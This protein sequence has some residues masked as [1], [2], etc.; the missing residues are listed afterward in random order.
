MLFKKQKPYREVGTIT[1]KLGMRRIYFGDRRYEWLNSNERFL[2][3]PNSGLNQHICIIGTSGSGKSNACK[4]IAKSI[5]GQGI[6]LAILDP[7]GEYTAF[8]ESIGASIYDASKSS[9][10]VFELDGMSE[11]EKASELLAMLKR[12]FRIGDVQGYTLHNCLMY[13]YRI[14]RQKNQTPNI[15]SLLFTIKVFYNKADLKEKR[16]LQS[17]EK[18]LSILDTERSPNSCSIEKILSENSVIVLQN[19]HN[20]E[21]QSI[22]IEGFL[23]KIYANMLSMKKGDGPRFYAIIDEAAKIRES[24][25]LAKIAAEGRKYGFG[26]IALSQR[27]KEMDKGLRAN[28]A[29]FLSFYQREPE[30]L[31]YIANYIAGGTEGSRFIEV[32]KALRTLQR[33]NAVILDSSRKDPI[34]VRFDG[35][36]SRKESAIDKIISISRGAISENEIM[37]MLKGAGYGAKEAEGSIRAALCQKMLFCFE[38]KDCGDYSGKWYVRSLRN[39]AEHDVS[40]NVIARKLT[41]NGIACTVYNSTN[42]PDIII[43]SNDAAIEYETGSKAHAATAD[44][45]SRRKAIYKNVLIVTGAGRDLAYS[46]LA[47]S[48]SINKMLLMDAVQIGSITGQKI[49]TTP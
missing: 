37:E 8:A 39:S 16:I 43:G 29:M 9:I 27:A 3:A 28:S 10:N 31:N 7:H 15:K 40:V 6:K 30:E 11:R 1:K 49:R 45:I 46:G 47:G 5:V 18:R 34:I 41:D 26:V 25:I 4:V 20:P 38:L 24:D 12:T 19:L 13:T 42:G 32:K 36:A 23:R 17:L 44:M 21:S 14:C 48:L 33:G 2:F 35:S 22:Y